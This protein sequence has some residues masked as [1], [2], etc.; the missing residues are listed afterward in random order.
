MGI[1]DLNF[2]L[3]SLKK[4]VGES[5]G[6]ANSAQAANENVELYDENGNLVKPTEVRPDGNTV[7][8]S[9][10]QEVN[11]DGFTPQTPENRNGEPQ[12]AKK[13]EKGLNPT[14]GGLG[15]AAVLGIAVGAITT[16]P[17]GLAAAAVVGLTSCRKHPIEEELPPHNTNVEINNNN[18]FN[19]NVNVEVDLSM[20]NDALIG[21][22]NELKSILAD[23]LAENQE[24]NDAL[25]LIQTLLEG[26]SNDNS[27]THNLLSTIIQLLYGQ[28]E[29]FLE[30]FQNNQELLMQILNKLDEM[31]ENITGFLQ[32]ILINQEYSS[33]QLAAILNKLNQMDENQQEMMN[34]ILDAIHGLSGQLAEMGVNVNNMLQHILANQNVQIEQLTE[35][36][37]KLDELLAKLTEVGEQLSALGVSLSQ[38]LEEILANKYN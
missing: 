11:E 35:I 2:K 28:Q 22:L 14:I 19:V 25:D 21:L 6:D 1:E 23:I 4:Q 24:G 3:E 36:L 38:Y 18:N 31:G 33:D 7:P 5:A 26:L 10:V 13:E 12:D 32:Q 37:A 29:A 9:S 34:N 15:L 8:L 20:D 16:W 27:T 30:F 17:V